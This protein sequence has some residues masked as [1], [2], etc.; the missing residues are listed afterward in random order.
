MVSASVA[1]TGTMRGMISAQTARRAV[2]RPLFELPRRFHLIWPLARRM[3]LA[4][5][6]GSALGLAWAVL[7]PLVLIAVFT[8]VFAEVFGARFGAGGTPLDYA[9]YLF[10]GLLP[11]TA[12]QE[13]VQ[14][15]SGVVVAHTNLVKRVV[16]PLETLP[17]AQALAAL[18]GQLFGTVALLAATVFLRG[19]LHATALWLPVL[20]VPQLLLTLGGS[21]LVASLGVFLRDTAQALALL[22]TAWM[23]LTPIIYP[24]AVVPARYGSLLEL[25]PFTPLVRSH[26]LCLLE[27]APPDW[28]GLSYTLLCGLILF[29][30]GYWWFARTR[31][32]FADVV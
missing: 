17:V 31:K 9:L 10:C 29:I 32:N 16:F 20:L 1:T 22:L 13:A 6:R 28:R 30:F 24:E 5:Y 19:E 25:N 18:A 11:W 23:Y 14:L 21:W 4:R 3:T 7:N 15:S 2:W 8:F 12:F 26:R 27:G